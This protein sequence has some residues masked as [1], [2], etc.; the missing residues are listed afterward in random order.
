MSS[1]S[2]LFTLWLV[3]N[4]T[5]LAVWPAPQHFQQDK[6]PI[7]LSN[8]FTIS[9]KPS[10]PT[11]IS[12]DLATAISTTL[13]QIQEDHHQPLTVDRGRSIYEA[14]KNTN[15]QLKL[16]QL[17]IQLHQTHRPSTA[18][19][20]CPDLV[21]PIS[22]KDHLPC[23]QTFNNSSYPQTSY[24]Q[25]H[26]AT[27]GPSILAE[28]QLPLKSRVESY[29]IK[30]EATDSRQCSALLSASSALGVLRGLQTF[31]QIV[32]TLKPPRNLLQQPI[33]NLSNKA[34]WAALSQRTRSLDSSM[35]H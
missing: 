33:K 16:H 14:L 11:T 19:N 17:S 3:V 32:Y 24:P 12:I 1:S 6:Q 27:N 26:I 21:Q 10:H 34:T 22:S 25:K 7:R 23:H 15:Q 5:V 13:K 28:M 4:S 18:S 31:S 29:E 35:A 8:N 2:W 9:F 30:I 20:A